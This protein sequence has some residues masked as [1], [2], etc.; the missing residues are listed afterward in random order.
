MEFVEMLVKW[1]KFPDLVPAIQLSISLLIGG[2]LAQYVRFLYNKFSVSI[3]N[4]NLV[5]G[6]FPLLT[7]VTICVIA[8][9][10]SSL[11]LSLGL[12]GALSIVRFRTAI[13]DPEE[14]V[15]LFICIAV[16]LALGAGQI[17]YAVVLVLGISVFVFLRRL[18]NKKEQTNNLMLTITADAYEYFSDPEKSPINVIQNLTNN[19]TIQR[20]EI[21]NDKGVL[22]VIIKK[23]DSKE[24]ILF[25]ADLKKKLP[26]CHISYVNMDIIL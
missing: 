26:M 8:V 2:V 4:T 9:V 11:A 25:V 21:N 12:V 10:K 16:G 17:V 23:L 15:Y 3:S 22:R 24:L 18:F 1:I 7:L 19:F 13:K 20:Y 5:S 6:I 14:L